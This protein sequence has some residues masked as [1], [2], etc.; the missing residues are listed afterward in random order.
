MSAKLPDSSPIGAV[1]RD[2]NIGAVIEEVFRRV[3]LSS[4]GE[5]KVMGLGSFLC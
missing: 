1:W 2:A 3:D 5:S 4:V